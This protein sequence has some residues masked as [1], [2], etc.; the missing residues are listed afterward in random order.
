MKRFATSVWNGT[1]K[2]GDWHPGGG[3][4]HNLTTITHLFFWFLIV[5]V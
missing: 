5:I 4:R 1:G 3:G 2:D